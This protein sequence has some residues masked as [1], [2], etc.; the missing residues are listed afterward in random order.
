MLSAPSLPFNFN[1]ACVSDPSFQQQQAWL[2][3]SEHCRHFP[4]CHLTSLL[5]P[6]DSPELILSLGFKDSSGSQT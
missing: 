2:A 3:A 6:F 5:D 4:P 1:S